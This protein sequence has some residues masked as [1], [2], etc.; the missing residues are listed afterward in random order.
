MRMFI[1]QTHLQIEL[2]AGVATVQLR[3]GESEPPLTQ[4]GWSPVPVAHLPQCLL[5]VSHGVHTL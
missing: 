2:V 1:Y 4:I 3:T 5:I